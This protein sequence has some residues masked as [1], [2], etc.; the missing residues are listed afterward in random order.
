MAGYATIMSTFW[1]STFVVE[2]RPTQ[3]NALSTLLLV[4]SDSTLDGDRYRLYANLAAVASDEDSGFVSASGLAMA[5][6][7]FAQPIAPSLIAIGRRDGAGSETFATAL[8]AIANEGLQFGM[9]VPDAATAAQATSIDGYV[10]TTTLPTLAVVRSADAAWI[11]GSPPSGWPTTS[12]STAGIYHPTA[13]QYPDVAACSIAAGI[14]ANLSRPDFT[15]PLTNVSTYDL[16]ET[17][18]AFALA[19]HINPLVPI[20]NGGTILYPPAG[21]LKAFSG[22]YLYTKFTIMYLTYRWYDSIS[23]QYAKFASQNKVWPYTQAGDAA[24][25]GCLVP[26]INVGLQ[27]GYFAPTEALPQGYK[28]TTS[29]AGGQI[30]ATAQVGLLDGTTQVVTVTYVERAA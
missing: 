26:A 30:T 20:Q 7:A 6:T 16:T 12:A 18:R 25:V 23:A 14:N 2:P 19:N 29:R 21:G 1:D 22:E 17:Q 24:L 9:V 27:V 28:I 15:S 13:G 8:A 10:A 5:T 3:N 4:S 11:T